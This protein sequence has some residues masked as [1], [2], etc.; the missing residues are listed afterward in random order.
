MTDIG[1]IIGAMMSGM[2]KAR[3]IADT[4]TAALAEQY[5]NNPLLEGLSV[6]RI[7]IPELSVDMPLIIEAHV[8]GEAGELASSAILSKEAFSLIKEALDNVGRKLPAATYARYA[9]ESRKRLDAMSSEK[10]AV[11]RE[12]AVRTFQDVLATLLAKEK[13]DLSN[14]EKA[15]LS[16][17]LR[18]RISTIGIKKELASP[19]IVSNVRT[20]DVKEKSNA[21]SVVRLKLT[22]REEGLEWATQI[23]DSGGTIKT[24]QPE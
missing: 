5:K 12:V 1:E 21:Q 3:Y 4:Q 2:L 6:P 22:F 16:G 15:S 14:A 8:G 17:K 20:A 19:T 18:A 24:L 7:R 23:T 11:S 13:I 10:Q 9:G